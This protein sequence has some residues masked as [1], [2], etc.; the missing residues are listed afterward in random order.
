LTRQIILERPQRAAL[1]ET[2]RLLLEVQRFDPFTETEG[3]GDRLKSIEDL[4]RDELLALVQD[5][6]SAIFAKLQLQITTPNG[7]E[8]M[9]TRKQA[10]NIVE[11]RLSYLVSKHPD[12]APEETG[13]QQLR[14]LTNEKEA[15]IRSEYDRLCQEREID[16][17]DER[18]AKSLRKEAEATIERKIEAAKKLTKAKK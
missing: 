11:G 7:P 18:Q 6:E 9:F 4:E 15:V 2:L 13:R 5:R 10:E 8:P 14:K 3:R 1:N 12:V 16:K 17:P